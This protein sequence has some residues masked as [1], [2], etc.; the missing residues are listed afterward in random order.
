ML[1]PRRWPASETVRVSTVQR[2]GVDGSTKLGRFRG[3]GDTCV[4]WRSRRLLGKPTGTST[5]G[6]PAAGR[7]GGCP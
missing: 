2:D 6:A 1:T 3:A 4:L 7:A 5:V